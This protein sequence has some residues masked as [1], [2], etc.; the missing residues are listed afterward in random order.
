[1]WI[2][3][4]SGSVSL[5]GKRSLLY[6]SRLTVQVKIGMMSVEQSDKSIQE[7]VSVAEKKWVGKFSLRTAHNPEPKSCSIMVPLVLVAVSP[8]IG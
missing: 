4:G 5:I 8:H 3:V 1:M 7:K 6:R 2:G